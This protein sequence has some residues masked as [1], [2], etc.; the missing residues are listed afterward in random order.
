MSETEQ[1]PA[2]ATLA[3]LVLGYPGLALVV[4]TDD[5]VLIANSRARACLKES[6]VWWEEMAPWR[7]EAATGLASKERPEHHISFER[8]GGTVVL[9]WHAIRLPSGLLLQGRDASAEHHLR[10][11]LHLAA[12]S[13]SVERHLLTSHGVV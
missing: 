13:A 4:G 11:R 5:A 1:P 9:A 6:V 12:E 3:A 2:D 8:S 7:A 10:Q